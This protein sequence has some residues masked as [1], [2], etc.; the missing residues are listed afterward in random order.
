MRFDGKRLGWEWWIPM[1]LGLL[2]TGQTT[3]SS[4]SVSL[5]SV[6]GA[7][8][9]FYPDQARTAGIEGVV[10]VSIVTGGEHARVVSTEGYPLLVNAAKENLRSWI[11]IRHEPTRFDVLYSYKLSRKYSCFPDTGV[12]SLHLP[13]SIEV[14]ATRAQTCDPIIRK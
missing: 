9:P 5:P 12:I 10:K 11:F 6:I 2:I 7:A 13:I 4:T 14:T 1:V 8:V 3:S